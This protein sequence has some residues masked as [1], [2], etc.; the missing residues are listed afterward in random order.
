MDFHWCFMDFHWFSLIFIEISWIFIDFHWFSMDFQWFSWIFI[1]FHW[2]SMI[3]N[4]FSRKIVPVLDS[5]GRP[6]APWGWVFMPKNCCFAWGFL[7]KQDQCLRP[8]GGLRRPSAPIGAHRR[9]RPPAGWELSVGTGLPPQTP[10]DFLILVILRL[11]VG[12]AY[13]SHTP[14]ESAD[15]N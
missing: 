6:S 9:R 1:D 12:V 13:C 8:L 14:E 3:F 4:G 2:F 11:L 10:P 15:I 7:Q 5:L